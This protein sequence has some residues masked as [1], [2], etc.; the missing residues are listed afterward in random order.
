VHIDG[1]SHGPSLAPDGT[2]AEKFAFVFRQ[3]T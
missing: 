3:D 2:M 1:Q